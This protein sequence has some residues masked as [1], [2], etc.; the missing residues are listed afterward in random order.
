MTSRTYHNV[1]YSQAQDLLKLSKGYNAKVEGDDHAGTISDYGCKIA[2][3]YDA[4]AQ[5]LTLSVV[6]T[7]LVSAD[8]V[9]NDIEAHSSLKG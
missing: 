3:Q 1:S 9:L 4:Q 7:I 6:R 5:V 8:T 2:Y